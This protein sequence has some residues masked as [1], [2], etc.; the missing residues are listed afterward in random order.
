[1][2]KWL[3]DMPAETLTDVQRAPRFYYLQHQCFG[4][5][6]QGQNWDTDTQAPPVNLLR[7]EEQLSAAHLRLAG[8]YIERMDWRECIK[9][10]DRPYTFFYLG[11]P[12]WQTEGYAVPFPFAEYLAMAEVLRGLKGKAIPSI[13]D[14]PSIREVF[15]GLPTDPNIRQLSDIR[16]QK[17]K[18]P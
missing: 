6:V 18:R 4:G 3:K 5:R 17:A 13:N 8:A 9:R 7:L 14:H 10:Y 11:P 12:Y 16:P 15:A 1:M 2:F